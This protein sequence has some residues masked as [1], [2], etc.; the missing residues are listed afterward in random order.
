MRQLSKRPTLTKTHFEAVAKIIRREVE[1]I[2]ANT[3]CCTARKASVITISVNLASYFADCNDNF[4]RSRFFKA[5]GLEG[6]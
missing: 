3:D 1:W 5:C 6:E 2:R 4:D